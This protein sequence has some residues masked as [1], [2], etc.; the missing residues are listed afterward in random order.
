MC[1]RVNKSILVGNIVLF[2]YFIPFIDSILCLIPQ[3]VPHVS[4]DER[5]RS[6]IEYGWMDGLHI[7]TTELKWITKILEL[8]TLNPMRPRCNL[9]NSTVNA[10][11]AQFPALITQLDQHHN[12]YLLFSI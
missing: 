6:G 7:K 11:L 10:Q 1:V 5:W 3:D 8:R 4:P 9:L 12:F 2:I